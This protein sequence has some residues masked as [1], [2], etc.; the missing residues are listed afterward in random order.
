MPVESEA[1]SR[2]RISVLSQPP[3]Y[4]Q[5]HDKENVGGKRAGVSTLNVF[6]AIVS[7]RQIFVSS[8]LT[9]TAFGMSGVRPS[10]AKLTVSAA[11]FRYAPAS[12]L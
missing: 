3:N 10:Q 2:L 11:V 4:K 5:H 7:P 12:Q 9:A 8:R 6:I 1:E